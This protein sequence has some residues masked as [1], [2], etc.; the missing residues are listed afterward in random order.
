MTE[1]QVLTFESMEA[2]RKVIPNSTAWV[3]ADS[4][5]CWVLVETDGAYQCYLDL[6]YGGMKLICGGEYE[7]AAGYM[8]QLNNV[9]ALDRDYYGV[10]KYIWR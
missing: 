2:Y 7:L 5:I 4:P 6:G 10:H 3:K 1:R 9:V 8:V